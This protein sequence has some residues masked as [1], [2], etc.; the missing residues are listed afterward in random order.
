MNRNAISYTLSYNI[1]QSVEI[2]DL[3]ISG[4]M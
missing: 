1:M 2:V 4:K 3:R